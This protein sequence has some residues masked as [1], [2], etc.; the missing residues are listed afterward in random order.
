MEIIETRNIDDLLS[1]VPIEMGI[2]EKNYTSL[3]VK[4]TLSFVQRQMEG[5]RNFHFLMAKNEN[6]VIGYCSFFIDNDP[7]FK[8]LCIYRV[9]HNPEHPSV[10]VRFKKIQNEICKTYKLNSI[11]VEVPPSLVPKMKEWG[12]KQKNIVMEKKVGGSHGRSGK[13]HSQ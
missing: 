1:L 13:K 11:K 9:W 8:S 7:G 5:N 10:L 12:F 6:D 3:S 4:D 2:R